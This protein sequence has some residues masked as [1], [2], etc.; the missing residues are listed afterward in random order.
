MKQS[1]HDAIMKKGEHYKILANAGLPIP[2]YRVFDSKCLSNPVKANELRL[3]VDQILTDG[4]GLIGVRTEPKER[5]SPLGNYPHLFPLRSHDEVIG[6]MRE[7]EAQWPQNSWWYL[8]NEGFL[9]YEWNAVV[10]LTQDGPLPGHWQ[11]GGE[12]NVT[13]NAPLR[14]ALENT[15]HIIQ[16]NNWKG[17]D[18][19]ELR[20]RI[21]RSGLLNEWLEVSKV[22]TAKGPRLIFWG[23]RGT[24][25]KIKS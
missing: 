7:H 20:K 22:R 25:Q 14:P 16:A 23:M 15:T 12:V 5:I 8:V 19:A 13:D 18:P 24:S 17:S 11:L 9:E 1:D 6:A 10:R 4:S 2:L 3:F 21:L